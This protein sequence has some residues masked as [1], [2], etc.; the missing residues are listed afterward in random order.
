MNSSFHPLSVVTT[1]N[2]VG[3]EN[4]LNL[5]EVVVGVVIGDVTVESH[6]GDCCVDCFGGIRGIPN[7]LPL[8]FGDENIGGISVSG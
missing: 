3:D 2:D 4:C 8:V 7:K 5:G 1:V 6:D